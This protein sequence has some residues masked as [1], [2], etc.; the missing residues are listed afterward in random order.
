MASSSIPPLEVERESTATEPNWLELPRDL[1]INILQRLDTIEIVTSVC[2]VCPLWW[3]ICKDPHMWHTIS[4]ILCSHYDY[5]QWLRMDL[6]TICRY[7]V[8]RSCGQLEG[9][10]IDF[11]L[12]D[13]LF[14]YISDCASHLRRIRVVTFDAADSLSEKGFIEGIKKLSM[15]EELEI[16]YPFKLSRNSIEVVGGSCPLLKSLTCMLTSDMKTGKSDDELFAIAKSMPRLR[17][18]KIAGN[19]LSSDGVLAILNECSLLESLD[20]GLCFRLDWSERLRK[21]CYDQIKDFKLPVDYQLMKM[22]NEISSLRLL[23]NVLE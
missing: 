17:H 10:D 7:S 1:T 19:N 2:Q 15:I 9:I 14:K 18:L 6:A 20:L 13:D 5:W 21:R 23:T 8:E 11:S 3:N 16:S 12:T 22:T 4:M